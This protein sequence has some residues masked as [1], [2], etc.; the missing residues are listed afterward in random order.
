MAFEDADD[1]AWADAW[2][3]GM[4]EDYE[5]RSVQN[6]TSDVKVETKDIS[7]LQRTIELENYADVQQ[8]QR[9]EDAPFAKAHHAP[10]PCGRAIW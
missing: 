4:L 10:A 9:E 8:L 1:E 2:V 6:A 5:K 3:N 7:S